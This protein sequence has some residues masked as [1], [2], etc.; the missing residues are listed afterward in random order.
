[1]AKKPTSKKTAFRRNSSA[2]INSKTSR[3]KP[4]LSD[5]SSKAGARQ[6]LAKEIEKKGGTMSPKGG[7]DKTAENGGSAFFSVPMPFQPE[8]GDPSKIHYPIDRHQQN[9][10]WRMYYKTDPA[11]GAVIDMFAEMLCSDFTITGEGVTGEIKRSLEEMVHKTKIISMFQYFIK[12]FLVVGEVV[13]HLIFD[14]QKGIWTDLLFHNPD[15]VN[16][17]SSPFMNMEPILEFI[18]DESLR[19]FA[20][21]KNPQVLEYLANIPQD[22]LS[23]ILTGQNI[24]LNTQMN[25]SFIAR[26]LFPYDIRGTSIM[27]RLWQIMMYEQSVMNACFV[28][29]TPIM[30]KN[31][32]NIP[33]EEIQVGDEVVDKDGNVQIVESAW[34]EDAKE[35]TEITLQGGYKFECTT[36]HKWPVWA[37]PRECQCGCGESVDNRKSYKSQ[38]G[39]IKEQWVSYGG[40]CTERWSK[41]RLPATYN[42]VHKLEAKDIKKHDYLMIPRAFDEANPINIS[43]DEARLLGYYVAEGCKRKLTKG[44]FGIRWNFN[45]NEKDTW[46]KDV[47]EICSSLNIVTATH[48]DP[49]RSSCVIDFNR[50]AYSATAEWFIEHGGEYSRTKVLSEEVMK[51]P[52][53]LKLE[54]IKGC[55]RG[56]GHITTSKRGQVSTGYSTSS[57]D[58]SY[59]IRIILNQLG[60]FVSTS[61]RINSRSENMIYHLRIHGKSATELIKIIWDKDLEI[62]TQVS[63]PWADND[64]IYVPVKKVET[65]QREEKV[66]NLTVSGTHSYLVDGVGT[67]N[68][69]QTARRHAG[70]VKVVK[71]GHPEGHWLPNE[72]DFQ[73]LLGK[74]T[75]AEQD[76]HTWLVNHPFIS[77]EAWGTTDRMI[78]ISRE[79]DLIERIKLTALGV[80]QGFLHGESN[81]ASMSGNMNTLMMRL[82]GMRTFFENVWW[83]PKFFKPIAEIN[84]WVRPSQ[85]EVSHRI[86]KKR[87]AAE[88]MAEGRLISPK[89]RWAQPLEPAVDKDLLDAIRLLNDLGVKTSKSTAFSA[90]SLDF[91]EETANGFVEQKL[92]KKIRD[93]VFPEEEREKSVEEEITA[94]S[95]LGG[96]GLPTE[97]DAPA[98]GS[99]PEELPGGEGGEPEVPEVT[100]PAEDGPVEPAPASRRGFKVTSN[101]V[102]DLID[103]M[104]TGKTDSPIW[105]ALRNKEENINEFTRDVDWERIEDYMVAEA[106]IANEIEYIRK[107][108][109]KQGVLDPSMTD[110][111]ERAADII[112]KAAISDTN[113]DNVLDKTLKKKL[114]EITSKINKKATSK[115]EE[116]DS[117]FTGDGNAQYATSD[118]V[119][120]GGG[121]MSK[122]KVANYRRKKTIAKK[123]KATKEK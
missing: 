68:S 107:G 32:K 12:E 104:E 18:P 111:L 82:R 14:E 72:G 110:E 106:F 78:T 60:Y 25:V 92:E 122:K 97:P 121:N 47:A 17:L 120:T 64:Y 41:R 93:K 66:Y 95:G 46:V 57:Y 1:M 34:E 96:F 40:A 117:F 63:A 26:K 103:L 11:V 80:S 29:K 123:K 50:H 83:Y 59:Q 51:W 27:P 67:Y 10:Y 75:M 119:V 100:S 24:P 21:S 23:A 98:D 8:F 113:I 61:S 116:H 102:E 94:P 4:V 2:Q 38:H 79:A 76:P 105:G 3:L 118:F 9:R 69:I 16:V 115:A 89:I 44:K 43:E 88:A 52:L 70:P 71:V 42:P 85:A 5:G 73:D 109:V 56:D 20:Q 58:L 112:N 28:P 36:N 77:F 19:D 22:I 74:L 54:F 65:V 90:A 48:E 30:L 49:S 6:A 37:F 45:I 33:I 7:M 114:K 53:N 99:V 87:T 108:L 35:I 91:E 15:Q 101:D 84:E 31:Y 86:K 81:Y 55:F 13:P 39:R 62:T